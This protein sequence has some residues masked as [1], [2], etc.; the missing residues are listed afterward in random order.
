MAGILIKRRKESLQ[1]AHLVKK[2]HSEK[3]VFVKIGSAIS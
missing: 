2:H 3:N 1:Y